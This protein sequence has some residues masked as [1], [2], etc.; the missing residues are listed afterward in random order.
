MHTDEYDEDYEEERATE[1]R[2]ILDEED[3]L[4]HHSSWKR[5]APSIDMTSWPSIDTQPQQRCRKRASTDTA[6]YKSVDT[7]VNRAREGNYSIGSWEGEH[8]HESFAVETA[9]YAPEEDKLQDSFTDEELLNMQRR[10]E[11]NQI[12]A[13]AAWE[14]TRFSQSIDTHRQQSIDTH[15]QQSIDTRRQQSINTRRQQSIDINNTTSIDNR[16]IPKSTVSEKDKSDKQY[17]TPDKFG[18]FRDPDGYAKAIDGRTLHVS[19]EDIADILQTANRADNLFMHQRSIPEQKTTKEFYDTAGATIRQKEK[20]EYGVYRDDREFARDLDGHTIPVHNKDI[21]R[22]LERDSR[23][24]PAYICLPEHASSFTQ[25]KLVPEIYTKDEINE[26]FYGVCGEHERNKEAFQMKL[27]GVYYPLNDSISWLTTCMEEIKQDIARI[28]NATDT[29]RPP[30]IDSRQPPSIDRHHHTSIDNRLT[31]SIDNNPSWTSRIIAAC[32]CGAEYESDYSKSIDTHPATSID[33]SHPKSTDAVEEKM[34]DTCPDEWEND[35][36]NPTIDAYT[37]QN[38]HTDEYDKDNEEERATEYR[39]IL[40]EEDKLLHHSSWKRNAPSIDMTSWPSIDT[41]PQQRCRKR[42][43]ID[44]AYYK[45]VDTDV[46]RAREGDYSI[47]SWADEHHHESFAVTATYALEADKLQDSFTDEELLNMQRRDETDQIQA[48]A[49]WERTHFSQSIETRHQ[50]SIDTRRQQSIDIKNTTLID[51]RPIPR[52]PDGYAKAIDGR[53]LHVFREDI[54]Y[55]L[56]TANG[57]DNLFMHQRSIPEQKTTKEFYGTDGGI[58]NCFKQRSR[59]TTHPSID[60]DVPTITRQLEFGRRA[61]DL[62]GNRKFYWEEKDEYGVYRDDRDELAYIC[63]PEHASSFTQTKLVPEIYTKN[64][65]NVMFY[66]VYGDHERNKEAFQMKLDGVY[67]PL[68][69]SISWLTTCM[70]EMKQDIARIQNATDTTRPPS[71]DKHQ[72]QSIDSRQPPSIDRHHHT[73]IDN[74][75]TASIDNN[76][77]RLLDPDFVTK[78]L[79]LFSVWILPNIESKMFSYRSPKISA[80]NKRKGKSKQG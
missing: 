75:L 62:Y 30:S 57:A 22:L 63:L 69:D 27:D 14:R 76:P 19:R 25:A 72:P 44:T 16:P 60:F 80:R 12:Q 37:K 61:Y 17:L 31:A 38:M 23:D 79:P 34:V 73:S 26:M 35:Y 10:D 11:T 29:A 33:T 49:A 59:H 46:N 7:D 41:Q 39:A 50:Q 77:P 52:D 24:E 4:L 47:G 67:Y 28:Q 21:R 58:E 55:I 9:T 32:H 36:Y 6:Y 13:E 68:N 70:E 78:S 45:S 5:N 42:A 3:K 8:H 1:Y 66:G 71:I 18:I 15:R 43:S 56:Q 64:E 65:I 74:R 2:A 53:T 54:A 51:N 48:E 20:D 40:D